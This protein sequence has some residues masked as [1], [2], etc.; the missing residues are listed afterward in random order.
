MLLRKQE[1]NMLKKNSKFVAYSDRRLPR[2]IINGI[3]FAAWGMCLKKFWQK[4]NNKNGDLID[5]YG[6]DMM[7]T[8]RNNAGLDFLITNGT[9]SADEITDQQLLKSS[10][11]FLYLFSLPKNNELSL[12]TVWKR[13]YQDLLHKYPARTIMQTLANFIKSESKSRRNAESVAETLFGKLDQ[14][15]GFEYGKLDVLMSTKDDL[16]ERLHRIQF[17]S[18]REDLVDLLDTYTDDFNISKQGRF[19]YIKK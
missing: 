2:F 1:R 12:V 9:I 14:L 3:D 4:M 13:F 19:F 6:N 5:R 10:E 11:M 7:E 16:S 18:I 17:D 8:L 15:L